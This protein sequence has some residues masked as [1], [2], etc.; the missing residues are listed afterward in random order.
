MRKNNF[1]LALCF[2]NALILSPAQADNISMN[3]AAANTTDEKKE[4]VPI[5]QD[6][7]GEVKKD[8]I[9]DS[10]GMEIRFNEERSIFYLYAETDIEPQTTKSYKIVI[11]DIWKAP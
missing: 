8:D 3:V 5:E 11:H 6:L 9:V 2:L 1:I 7:P 4:K 10:G